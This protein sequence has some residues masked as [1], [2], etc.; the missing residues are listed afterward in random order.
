MNLCLIKNMKNLKTIFL[1]KNPRMSEHSF[2]EK[3]FIDQ[4]PC[5]RYFHLFIENDNISMY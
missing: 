1:S 5:F 4:I 3:A 2:E